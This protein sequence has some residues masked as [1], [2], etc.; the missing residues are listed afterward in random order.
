MD[1]A[2]LFAWFERRSCTELLVLIAIGIVLLAIA[3]FAGGAELAPWAVLRWIR[4]LSTWIRG[5]IFGSAVALC[6]T[7][8]MRCCVPAKPIEPTS[9]T[10]PLP[11]K[12]DGGVVD[13]TLDFPR[14]EWE[15][16]EGVGVDKNNRRAKL[17]IHVLSKEFVWEYAKWDSII[18]Y[19][20][21]EDF[22]KHLQSPGL[23]ADMSRAVSLVA[24]GA[25]SV[26]GTLGTEEERADRRAN[27]MI[28][29]LREGVETSQRL[30]TLNLGKYRA[31]S[32]AGAPPEQTAPQRRVVLVSTTFEEPGVD[33]RQA[34]ADELGRN[35]AFPFRLTDYSQFMLTSAR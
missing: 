23:Q 20:K 14:S 31:P 1:S 12:A 28:V 4:G 11:Q 21:P 32:V 17:K 3:L 34:L 6:L 19:D 35:A 10:T 9:T 2:T 16:S 30:Y 26:E 15:R 8:I 7:F 29:W 27:Q 33:L 24:I 13:R 25:A 22:I 18:F 5:V